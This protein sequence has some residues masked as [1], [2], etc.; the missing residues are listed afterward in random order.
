MKTNKNCKPGIKVFPDFCSSGIWGHPDGVMI[1]FEELSISKE[2]QKEFE[3]WINF[4]DDECTGRPSYCLLKKKEKVLNKRGIELARKLKQ[5]LPNKTV[6]Y[7]PELSGS[8]MG[9]KLIE[10]K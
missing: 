2:L 9:R 5:E 7:W 4:Y 8:K 6:Y 1:D 10:V 3:D